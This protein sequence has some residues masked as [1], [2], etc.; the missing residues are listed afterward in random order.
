MTQVRGLARRELCLGGLA[1]AALQ[2]CATRT[3][4][5]PAPDWAVKLRDLER[6]SGVTIGA[7]VLEVGTGNGFGWNANMRFAM[8]SSFKLSLAALVLRM[9]A[10][11][12]ID[13]N[14]LVRYAEADL[15]PYSPVTRANLATGMTVFGLAQAAQETSDNGAANLLLA[16]V[17]GPAAVTAF[18]RSIGDGVSRLDN[19]EPALNRV[20]PNEVHDTTTPR[21]MA[22]SVAAILAGDVLVPA[23]RDRL[24]GWAAD[25]KTGLQRIRAGL[26]KG[27]WVGDKTGTGPYADAPSNY[28]DIALVRPPEGLP[29]VVTGFVRAAGSP[30][31][32]GAERD[33]LLAQVGRI[34]AQW[35]SARKAAA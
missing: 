18:W 27:W 14:A 19:N 15:Q 30:E 1:F 32:K 29:F 34:A 8:C 35:A 31:G 25:T 2:G 17:G 12:E 24:C 11:G 21:A 22:N 5:A 7:C 33:A 10:R 28:I 3:V 6:T 20:M 9:A 26:P 16:R 23:D 13:G 4:A